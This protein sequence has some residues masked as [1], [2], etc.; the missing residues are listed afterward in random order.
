MRMVDTVEIAVI[1]FLLEGGILF[2]TDSSHSDD[3]QADRLSSV[4]TGR[5]FLEYE[6]SRFSTSR[7]VKS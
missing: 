4:M 5:M 7:A 3:A 1:P 2:L 6:V